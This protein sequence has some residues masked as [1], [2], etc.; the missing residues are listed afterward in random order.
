MANLHRENRLM[1]TCDLHILNFNE[2]DILPWALKHYRTFCKRMIVHDLGSTDGSRE[3]AAKLGAEI[4]QHDCKGEF[5]DTLNQRIKNEAWRG[6]DADWVIMAD[7]DELI[8]FPFGAE[9]SL[10]CYD[11]QAV[12]VVKPWGFEML[13]DAMPTEGTSQI[14]DQVK[15]GGRDDQWYAKPILFS[16]KRVASISFGTGAHVCEGKTHQ[17]KQ[18]R[19]PVSPNYPTCLLLH[20][21]HI[22]GVDRIARRY[23]EN[24]ARRSEINKRFRWGNFEPG[25]K[26]A[27][28]KRDLI[29]KTHGRVIA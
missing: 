20:F 2:T 18:I 29:M 16:P 28:D 6:T 25:I 19:N 17:G 15:Y 8:Y 24:L 23:D 9:A 12:P 11:A 7:A 13:H 10:K 14:Y 3:E 27:R 5:D 21:H 1:S 4:I 22:G 26:H